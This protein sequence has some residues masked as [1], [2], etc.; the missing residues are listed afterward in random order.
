VS[1]PA[2]RRVSYGADG[3][4][5]TGLTA[6]ILPRLGTR[7]C[8][9]A[10]HA[11]LIERADDLVGCIEGSPDEPR[12]DFSSAQSKPRKFAIVAQVVLRHARG[13]ERFSNAALTEGRSSSFSATN[14]VTACA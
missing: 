12:R 1:T 3:D 2:T 11:L 6:L 14:P 5:G 8:P 4:D 13:G 9:D 10:M 7:R